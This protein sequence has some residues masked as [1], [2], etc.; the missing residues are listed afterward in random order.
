MSNRIKHP[1]HTRTRHTYPGDGNWKK[2]QFNKYVQVVGECGI[3]ISLVLTVNTCVWLTIGTDWNTQRCFFFICSSR[4][5]PFIRKNKLCNREYGIV[6][7]Y[8]WNAQF[9]LSQFFVWRASGCPFTFFPEPH[10]L[11]GHIR[12]HLLNTEQQ[13][14]K[15]SHILCDR[16]FFLTRPI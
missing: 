1:S 14:G 13:P 6:R 10:L 3:F 7:L 9:L 11:R 15:S 5:A 2:K 12:K 8:L 4:L 16:G